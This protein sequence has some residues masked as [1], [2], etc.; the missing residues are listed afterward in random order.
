MNKQNY[1]ATRVA[2]LNN[3]GRAIVQPGLRNYSTQVENGFMYYVIPKQALEDE[4]NGA[5]FLQIGAVA[6]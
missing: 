1:S 4:K 6:L 5:T 3:L 2:E